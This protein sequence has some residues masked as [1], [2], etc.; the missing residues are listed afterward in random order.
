MKTINNL[1]SPKEW[2]QIIQEVNDMR[3]GHPYL[4][5]GQCLWNI[6][7]EKRPELVQRLRATNA[8]P[9]YTGNDEF[10]ERVQLFKSEIVDFNKV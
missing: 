1:L 5:F 2:D 9:F 8:D 3:S 7:E 4:R 10:H 6:V